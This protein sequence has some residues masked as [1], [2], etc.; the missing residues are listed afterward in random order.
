M[1]GDIYYDAVVINVNAEKVTYD[2]LYDD[3]NQI[4]KG[5]L[6]R[7]ID[8]RRDEVVGV[9]E[10]AVEGVKATTTSSSSIKEVV[11]EVAGTID[12][13]DYYTV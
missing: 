5:V 8:V 10:P 1:R 6:E 3:D 2:I 4:E 13:I 11:G 12:D 7:Y 9:E